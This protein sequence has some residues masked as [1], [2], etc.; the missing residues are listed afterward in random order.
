MRRSSGRETSGRRL[1]ERE[2]ERERERH[3]VQVRNYAQTNES[4]FTK[5]YVI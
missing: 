4:F 2:R 1:R 5:Q 3:W